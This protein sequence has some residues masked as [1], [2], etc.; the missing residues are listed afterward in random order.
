[1]KRYIISI[2]RDRRAEAPANWIELLHGI[3]DLH[4]R[5]TANPHR[6]QVDASETAVAEARRLLGELCHIEPSISH[7]F[8]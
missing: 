1:M 6:I 8:N 2:K 3:K 5:G 4:I 7:R